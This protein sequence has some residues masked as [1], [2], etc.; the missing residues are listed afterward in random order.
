MQS[1]S[2]KQRCTDPRVK[3][4]CDL[5]EEGE[6][7]GTGGSPSG[8]CQRLP[9]KFIRAHRAL[10]G[11]ATARFAEELHETVRLIAEERLCFYRVIRRSR[12]SL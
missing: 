9:G 3:D 2:E 5:A 11:D 8:R 7:K 10:P 12:A 1:K 4:A 6:F